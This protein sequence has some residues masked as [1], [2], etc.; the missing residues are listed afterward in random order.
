MH[1]DPRADP[2]PPVGLIRLV[3]NRTNTV[4][5]VPPKRLKP[6]TPP[7]FPT[8]RL[9]RLP[10]SLHCWMT[11]LSGE[12]LAR[13]HRCL[14]ALLVLDCQQQRWLPPV[15]PAQACGSDGASWTLDL[16][17]D[18]PWPV[19]RRIG[20]S[21][22]ARRGVDVIDAAGC[23]PQFDAGSLRCSIASAPP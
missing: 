13:H 1:S 4:H 7:A 21:F 16:G 8:F 14:A 18:A 5:V 2:V 11:G 3:R 9:P 10:L 6:R 15:L 17:T 19:H 20:G 23:V 22:Q 12:F